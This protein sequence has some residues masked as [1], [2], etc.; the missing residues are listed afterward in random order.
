MAFLKLLPRVRS[1][2][3]VRLREWFRCWDVHSTG[4]S[5][6]EDW[7]GVLSKVYTLKYPGAEPGCFGH[8]R[9]YTRVYTRVCAGYIP[10]YIPGYPQNIC[11]A[12]YSLKIVRFLLLLIT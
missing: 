10:G 12:K 1:W 7:R 5:L 3:V 4:F 11:L 6:A 8:T 2:S 9:I